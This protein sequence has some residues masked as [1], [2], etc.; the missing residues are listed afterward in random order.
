MTTTL[1][2]RDATL[3]VNGAPEKRGE[4][5]EHLRLR[6]EEVS[7]M[8][9]RTAEECVEV[10][11]SVA[12]GEAADPDVLEALVIIGLAHPSL[13]ERMNL[14][15]EMTGRRL[16]ARLER[17]ADIDRSVAVLE[18][19][20][21]HFPGQE[22][23]ESD[24]AAL[25]RRQG[26]VQDLV[27]RYFERA[28][29]LV[30]EGRNNEAAGWLREVLQLDPSRKDAAR[31]LRN[32]RFKSAIRLHKRKSKSGGSTFVLVTLV[33]AVGFFYG[34][35]REYRLHGE[36]IAL[37]E[38]STDSVPALKRR[39]ADL[40]SFVDRHPVWHGMFQVLAERSE[41]RIQLAVLEEKARQEREA[42]ER[43]LRERLESAELC[44][45][46]GLMRIQAG[47]THGALEAFR[48]ALEFGGQEWDK[49]ERVLRDV[50]DLE[51]SAKDQQ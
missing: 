2:V 43:A 19:L 49:R 47:D 18:L 15:T 31:L 22:A 12:G 10:L 46:R 33:L 11:S 39:L 32:M 44:R 23:L 50:S 42:V 45:E 38:A 17:N 41:L 16:A 14:P 1:I 7:H 29:R 40:E 36:L 3:A 5:R 51:A 13:A 30:R 20:Q 34:L 28:H 9:P 27:S 8:D 48:E 25:M 37:P 24:L 26:M 21:Q 4:P 35:M 6:I